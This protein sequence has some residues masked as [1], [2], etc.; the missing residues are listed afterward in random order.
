MTHRASA[1][2][3]AGFLINHTAGT[4]EL[5]E[6]IPSSPRRETGFPRES[7]IDHACVVTDLTFAETAS[8]PLP[9]TAT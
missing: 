7:A 5:Q 1:L 9:R 4:R 3:A 8:K 2:K 6:R